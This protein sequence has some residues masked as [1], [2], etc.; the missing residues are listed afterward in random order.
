MIGG[1]PPGFGG[2]GGGGGD[3][4]VTKAMADLQTALADSKTKPEQLKEKVAAVRVARRRA[5]EKLETARKDLIDLLTP[6]QEAVLIS[7]GYL[8]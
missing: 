5:K 2:M 3:A 1:P 4:A 7:L 8:D 6:E